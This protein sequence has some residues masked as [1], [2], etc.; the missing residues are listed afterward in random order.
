[1]GVCLDTCHQAVCFETVA[2]SLA[3]LQAAGVAVAKVQVSAAPI[4]E[5][6]T[7]ALREC[8]ARFC[9]PVYLHQCR[10]RLPAG[11]V[12][13]FED[14]PGF[15]A[16]AAELPVA[17]EVRTH[18]HIPLSISGWQGLGSTRQQL[19]RRFFDLLRGGVTPH[20]ELETYTFSVL[21]EELQARGVEASLVAEFTWFLQ[22]WASAGAG[23]PA[24]KE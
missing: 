12:L 7:P 1:L 24:A 8:L 9:D 17:A 5:R 19:D 3:R 10:V 23:A 18:V 13:Q 15:L 4:A 2:D 20:V 14:L 6:N 22:E 11:T 16:V 21:P